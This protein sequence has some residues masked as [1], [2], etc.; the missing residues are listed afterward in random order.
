MEQR[1]Q[2]AVARVPI[3]NRGEVRPDVRYRRISGAHVIIE[4]KRASVV[5]RK[6]AIEDQVND[7][8]TAVRKEID[9]DPEE[10]RYP[11]QAIS[12]LGRLPTGWDNPETRQRD[13]E[14]LRG[15]GIRVM[16]YDELINRARSA[17]AKFVQAQAE[18]GDLRELIEAIRTHRPSTG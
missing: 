4:L 17:Y 16:T 18:F 5:T 9:K 11:I 6:T 13:E 2:N 1:L 10:S 14:S 8:I 3:R 12:L 7:Y 15:Y